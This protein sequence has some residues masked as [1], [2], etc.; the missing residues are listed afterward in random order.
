[1]NLWISEICGMSWLVERSAAAVVRQCQ[2]RMLR[3][4]DV[5]RKGQSSW[6]KWQRQTRDILCGVPPVRGPSNC[7]VTPDDAYH[8]SSLIHKSPILKTVI[9][10]LLLSVILNTPYQSLYRVFQITES[11][12]VQQSQIPN[13]ALQNTDA[14]RLTLYLRSGRS[15]ACRNC[16]LCAYTEGSPAEV[17]TADGPQHDRSATCVIAQQYSSATS[18]SFRFHFS[19][20]NNSACVLKCNFSFL[21]V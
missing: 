13:R 7:R 6:H 19:K 18:V 15:G 21:F 11:S 17:W 10:F 8:I 14:P 20:V 1:M 12:L 16:Q 5:V 9:H 4:N 3:T 2:G